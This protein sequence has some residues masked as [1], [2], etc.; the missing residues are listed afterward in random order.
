M[1]SMKLSPEQHIMVRCW[2]WKSAFWGDTVH[3]KPAGPLLVN[4]NE[5][6]HSIHNL[7]TPFC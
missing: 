3:L 5:V 7:C 2:S 1:N 6:M 4:N